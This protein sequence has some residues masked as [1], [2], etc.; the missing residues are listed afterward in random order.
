VQS[1]ASC[2]SEGF[3]DEAAIIE[4]ILKREKFEEISRSDVLIP[5]YGESCAFLFAKKK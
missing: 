4:E 1:G 2:T 3:T 5:S